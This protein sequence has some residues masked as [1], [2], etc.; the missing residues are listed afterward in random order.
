MKQFTGFPIKT[1]YAPVPAAFFSALL[2]EITDIAELK[3][4]LHLF[5]ILIPMKRRPCFVTYRELA[6]DANLLL[7]LCVGNTQPE[8]TLRRA[9]D[10]AVKRGTILYLALDRD[11]VKEEIYLLNTKQNS[12]TIEKIRSGELRLP[13]LELKQGTEVNTEPQSN[14]F[15]LYEENIGLLTPMIAEDLKEAEKLY[16]ESWIK[17][18]FKEAVKANKR[19]WRF[20]AF[21]LERWATEGKRDG[22]YQRNLK[23]TDPDKFIKGKYGHLFQR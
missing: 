1:E 2:P 12:D 10:M 3:T 13:H 15:T 23:A 21:L 16:P 11:G 9:L 14:I 18:A 7:G 17:D 22:T 8:E 6:S 4:T 5:R 19:S 20:V